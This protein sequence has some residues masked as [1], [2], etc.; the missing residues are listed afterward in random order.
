MN[1]RALNKLEKG[2]VRKIMTRRRIEITPN[3]C[4]F[5]FLKKLFAPLEMVW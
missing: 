1:A 2:S 5:F 4:H 3:V